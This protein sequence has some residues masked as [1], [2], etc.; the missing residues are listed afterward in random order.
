MDIVARYN[1][2]RGKPISP[3]QR[4]AADYTNDGSM[5][6]NLI[7][8]R[9]EMMQRLVYDKRDYEELVEQASQD[10][11]KALNDLLKDFR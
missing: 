8:H 7:M 6:D 3:L 11:Y 9:Q 5:L 1:I 10:I 4:A 2:Q